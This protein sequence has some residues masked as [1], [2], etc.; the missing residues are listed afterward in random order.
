MARDKTPVGKRAGAR[1]GP[2][3]KASLDRGALGLAL[4]ITALVVAWGYLVKTAVDFGSAA[5]GGESGAWG[6]LALACAGAAACL[7][8]G[9]ILIA[10]LLRK[11]GI[12]SGG[13]TTPA[14]EPESRPGGGGGGT[15][16]DQGG[17]RAAR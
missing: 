6:F 5:R 13:S 2:R 4:A 9:L 16:R 7:F 10:R 11:L 1:R 14:D 15:S 17:R 3:K 12:T 8:V